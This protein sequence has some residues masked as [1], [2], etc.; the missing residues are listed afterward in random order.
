[1]SPHDFPATEAH[2]I[3]PGGRIVTIISE[4]QETT[5]K[6]EAQARAEWDELRQDFA[7][8]RSL[9]HEMGVCGTVD[10]ARLL[11]NSIA[12]RIERINNLRV[13]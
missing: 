11:T 5:A 9:M 4:T 8:L 1:M 10:S 2:V 13:L 3:D 6:R 7:M 12:N